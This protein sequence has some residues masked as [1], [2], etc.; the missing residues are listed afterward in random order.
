MNVGV[1][2]S[3]KS[4]LRLKSYKSLKLIDL[5]IIL[6]KIRQASNNNYKNYTDT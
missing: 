3:L 1:Q 4:E 2:E 6:I 5:K